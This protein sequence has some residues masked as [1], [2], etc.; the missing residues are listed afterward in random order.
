MTTPPVFAAGQAVTAEQLQALGSEINTYT[1]TLTAATTNPTLGTGATA[2]GM[3]TQQGGLVAVWFSLQFGTSPGAGSGQYRVSLPV[4]I[5]PGALG[6]LAIGSGRII[7]SSASASRLIVP[8][9][10][11]GFVDRVRLAVEA[12]TTVTSSA[13]WTWAASDQ[14]YGFVLYPGD[15]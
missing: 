3:W 6:S 10:A 9:L 13:P 12:G 14:I 4:D 15:F 11:A 8:E 7:D 2:A 5:A 1:P